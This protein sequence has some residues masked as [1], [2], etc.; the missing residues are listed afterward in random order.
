L[1]DVAELLGQFL[2]RYT[3]SARN[4]L[5]HNADGSVDPYLQASSPGAAKEANWLPKT[6]DFRADHQA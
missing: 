6:S 3:L 4:A 2:N 5:K 1:A